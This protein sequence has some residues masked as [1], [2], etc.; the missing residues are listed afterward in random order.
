MRY[1]LIFLAACT[2]EIKHSNA[3]ETAILAAVSSWRE[4]RLPSFTTPIKNISVIYPDTTTFM[5]HCH[6]WPYGD[7]HGA[8][9]CANGCNSSMFEDTIVVAALHPYPTRVIVHEMCHV[10]LIDTSKGLGPYKDGD[11]KHT[12]PVVW[13]NG[14]DRVEGAAKAR[15]P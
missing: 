1:L 11:P 15:L 13:G 9:R 4:H 6:D 8:A 3:E 14:L 5:Q 12:H 10:M 7:C 2:A